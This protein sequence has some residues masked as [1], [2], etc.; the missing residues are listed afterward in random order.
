MAREV[1][2]WVGATN[3]SSEEEAGSDSSRPSKALDRQVRAVGSHSHSTRHR[4][5]GHAND[6]VVSALEH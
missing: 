5:V 2:S 3:A 6:A 1:V 4:S